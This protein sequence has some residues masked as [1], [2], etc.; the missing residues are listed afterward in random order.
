M[1]SEIP[2]SGGRLNRGRLVRLGDYVLR[3]A[4]E[5]PSI[6]LL[7]IEVGKVLAGI[8]KTF[9]RDSLGRLKIEWIDGECAESFEEDEVESRIRLLSI[10]ALLRGLHD[11]TAKIAT[12]IPATLRASLDPSGVCEVV[13]HGD[14][15]PG[16]IV[17]REG[18]AFALIDWEMSAPGR[19]SW[20]L[21]TALRYW[22]PFR[23]P[24]NKKPAELLLDPM[25]RSEWILDGY[26]ASR[27]L[28][29]ETVKLLPLNQKTQADYVI[30]RIKVRGK[31]VF[32]EWATKGG[33]R[34]LELDEAWLSGES[35][36]LLQEWRLD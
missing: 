2:I 5:D 36:R 29:T 20:D 32:E 9:G 4:D 15:G 25:Q 10:G 21:A 27:E 24:A 33:V 6:E 34:R 1:D 17:F 13:C 35:E 23:N 31:S 19:R 3:P 26:S 30:A 16:N 12:G 8:P 7:M 18:K 22:A 11:C 14:A 28:R